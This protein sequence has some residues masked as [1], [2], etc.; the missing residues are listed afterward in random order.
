MKKFAVTFSVFLYA[1]VVPILE[2]NK[3]HVF[4]P[5]F[6]AHAKIH[7]VWQ[8]TTNTAIGLFCL[9]LTWVKKDYFT[10]IIL[11]ILVTGG[12]L[13]AFSIK[14]LYGGSMKFEDGTEKA[15]GGLN[16]GIIGFGLAIMLLIYSFFSK[17]EN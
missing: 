8:L 16:I 17:K 7:E 5:D 9:W 10:S 14:E 6:T 4:S 12:F 3:T 15:I 11:S 1:I 13:F 2:I